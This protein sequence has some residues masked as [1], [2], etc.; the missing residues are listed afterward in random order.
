[1]SEKVLIKTCLSICA[2][3][4]GCILFPWDF[5]NP[6]STEWV[7]GSGDFEANFLGWEFYRREPFWQIP[8][9]K[10]TLYGDG[11]A[12]SIIFTDSI[13][14]I[15]LPL[16]LLIGHLSLDIQY[17]GLFVLASL[18]L[19][20]LS[21]FSYFRLSGVNKLASSSLSLIVCVSPILLFRATCHVSLT[22]HWLIIAALTLCKTRQS[23]W[24]KWLALLS[25][26]LWIHL[27]LFLMCFI[28]FCTR[29]GFCHLRSIRS[30]LR[31]LS[32]FVA[33]I[34]QSYLLGYLPRSPSDAT[35]SGFGIFTFNLLSPL[36]SLE[37]LSLVFPDLGLPYGSHEGFALLAPIFFVALILAL[38]LSKPRRKL[39][40]SLSNTQIKVVLAISL[41]ALFAISPVISVGSVV[42][43]LG[44][45]P[46]PF[47]II[48]DTF[49]ASGR[50]IWPLYYFLMLE[51]FSSIVL[52]YMPQPLRLSYCKG[53][54]AL[55]IFSILIVISLGDLRG[56]SISRRAQFKS[57]SD[58]AYTHLLKIKQSIIR[59]SGNLPKAYVFYPNVEAPHGFNIFARLA[60]LTSS[61]TNGTYLARYNKSTLA[62][63]NSLNRQALLGNRLD[64]DSVYILGDINEQESFSLPPSCHV[65]N[66]HSF[67]NSHCLLE[68]EDFRLLAPIPNN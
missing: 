31:I 66:H 20:A 32:I 62:K 5:L 40:D 18:V 51:T 29:L 36:S 53:R 34:A 17:F 12:Q 8:L 24:L 68:V 44:R 38:C 60:L 9:S 56:Y 39:F 64:L 61:S 37:N 33:I 63:Q 46:Y 59:T 45:L 42:F 16:K 28:L 57:H 10:L 47:F 43:N 49:R 23:Q 25:M 48:G 50:F 11:I 30:V 58:M 54:L 35:S 21:A 65:N 52:A 14:I 67:K 22:A 41:M 1:M 2:I 27:Y 6:F 55:L 19:Q 13:P 26:A 4:I 3:L 7:W 15:A